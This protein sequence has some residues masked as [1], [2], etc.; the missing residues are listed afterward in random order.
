MTKRIEKLA[1]VAMSL[2][3]ISLI[4]DP[5]L[6]TIA[7]RFGGSDAMALSMAFDVLP[8]TL[9]NIV[10]VAVHLAV[11]IWLFKEAKR[12]GNSPYVYT[13][14]EIQGFRGCC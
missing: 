14:L 11:A 7:M 5:I 9:R 1:I 4:L 3:L 6:M 8:I 12:N 10:D 13:Y 2:L